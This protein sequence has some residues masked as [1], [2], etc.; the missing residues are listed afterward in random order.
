[1]PSDLPWLGIAVLALAILLGCGI[2][3]GAIHGIR[4][5]RLKQ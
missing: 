4:L 2:I 1:M 5:K 3:A